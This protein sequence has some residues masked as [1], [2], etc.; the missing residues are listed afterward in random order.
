MELL[1]EVKIELIETL[2][3]DNFNLNHLWILHKLEKENIF[4]D[5]PETRGLERRLY[6]LDN[7]ITERGK[8]YYYSLITENTLGKSDKKISKD[9]I[10]EAFDKWWGTRGTE[11]IYPS[12][13]FFIHEGKQFLGV[14]KKNIKKEDCKSEFRKIVLSG[15]YTSEEIIQ[16]TSKHIETAKKDSIKKKTNQITFIG[17]SLRYLKERMFAP[18]VN[19][20]EIK[21][22]E[23]ERVDPNNLF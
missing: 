8:D 5:I 18:F 4:V 16:G 2:K 6:I 15:E 10:N 14:Q 19:T 23:L 1:G 11:G 22:T 3:K 7:Q 21:K 17:N 20:Q 13:D 9:E 12:T